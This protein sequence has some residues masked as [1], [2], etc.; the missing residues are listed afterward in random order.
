[1]KSKYSSVIVLFA[2]LFLVMARESWTQQANWIV[3]NGDWDT[4]SNWD[5]SPDAPP[6]ALFG[7]FGVVGNSVQADGLAFI[8]GISQATGGIILGNGGGQT[9]SLE[10]RS[11]GSIG[12]ES[13]LGTNG[14]VQVG[15]AG[16][17][18]LTIMRGGTLTSLGLATAGEDATLLTLGETGGAGDATLTVSGL[19]ELDRTTRIIGP[20]VAF[21]TDELALGTANV[22]IAEVTGLPH[23]TVSVPGSATLRGTMQF[24]FSG[25]APSVGD[26]WDIIDAGSITGSWSTVEAAPGTSLPAGVGLIASI[27]ADGVHGNVARVT[28][29]S[30][31]VLTVNRDTGGVSMG[32][33]A[34]G[35][36]DFDSYEVTSAGG[37]LS[38][39]N[40]NSLQDQ[41]EPGWQEIGNP[42]DNLLA[43][44]N[45]FG[46]TVVSSSQSF[47]LGSAYDFM[48]TEFGQ[49]GSD[50]QF[51]Y[52][53]ASG[54]VVDGIVQ[55]EGNANN[56]VLRV[57]PAT[58]E[59]GIE[60]QSTFSVSID[61]YEIASA[62]GSLLPGDSDWVSLEDAGAPGWLEI[63][64]PTA[65]L[66]AELV[67]LGSTELTAG[68][69]LSLGEPFAIGGTQDLG[70]SFSIAGGAIMD[71]IIQYG[72][73]PMP[74]NCDIDG[75]G[76]CDTDD[77]RVLYDDID[78]G[79]LGGPSDIDGSGTVDN[80]DI[81]AWLVVAGTE[82]GKVY[83]PGDTDLDGSVG[84]PD[85][86][87]LAVNFGNTGLDNPA[88]ND[89]AY[90]DQGNFNG[91]AGGV[92]ETGGPDFTA[93]ALNFGH[94]SVNSVP[95]PGMLSSL[96]CILILMSVAFR[97]RQRARG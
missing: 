37:N 67:P 68:Q 12:V 16:T 81:D 69:F 65:N 4:P 93:L 54:A 82:N 88:D 33:L 3:P 39:A 92:F 60:N 61:G 40:W 44:L 52:S 64:N 96:P 13:N 38:S 45:P 80:D 50:V 70:F 18:N 8:D 30:K 28:V 74:A 6:L 73:L 29:D 9:G 83:L 15:N 1:M 36:T 56:L 90:W 55:Y 35:M 85:F 46:S 5:T 87:Q 27:V 66:L 71:G 22:M 77:M 20:N 19:T 63:G 94:V 91:N 57:D 24:D 14:G 23:S 48:P 32:N 26:F 97:N 43:E 95:E 47:D 53:L 25:Y 84:G 41:A 78:A 76:V 79:T 62:A 49:N 75:N 17:G 58:G 59:A 51:R 72:T 34:S 21:E 42:S 11:G 10:I 31:L 7:E 2:L 86:T 89:N